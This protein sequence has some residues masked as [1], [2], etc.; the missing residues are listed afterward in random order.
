[1]TILLEVCVDDADGLLAAFSGRADRI[2]LCSSLELGGLTPQLSLMQMAARLP[3]PSYA[4]VRPRAGDFVYSSADIDLM[5]ADIDTIREAGL[6]GVVLG[7]SLADGRLDEALLVRL[8]EHAQGLGMTL[9]RAFDLVPDIAPA[10]D[11]AAALGFERIL[12]SGGA[13]TA[14]A[15]ATR[16]RQTFEAAAGRIA[17]MPGSGINAQTAPEILAIA[18]F[19]ELHSSCSTYVPGVGGKA[20]EL[21]FSPPRRRA[22]S[23][24]HVTAL[25]ELLAQR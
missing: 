16:L 11:F 25:K 21:G 12:T 17:I 2:E 3:I 1:M 19:G 15:G 9:H 13:P 7:A 5:L 4:M 20:E 18:P 22:T 10:L 6:A 24:S 14:T 8:V 23:A